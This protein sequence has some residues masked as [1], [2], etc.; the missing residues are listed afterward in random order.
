ML[1]SSGA[2]AFSPIEASV[3]MPHPFRRARGR[4]PRGPRR[5][6]PEASGGED[7]APTSAGPQPLERLPRDVELFDRADLTL[8]REDILRH[9]GAYL[10][11]DAHD[12][13]G[14]GEP[15]AGLARHCHSRVLS[16][17]PRS[18]VTRTPD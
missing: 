3:E 6:T 4:S 7:P 12:V 1:P 11:N 5:R 13:I 17:A 9:K 8:D 14:N 2:I 18:I 15:D 10:V 16:R